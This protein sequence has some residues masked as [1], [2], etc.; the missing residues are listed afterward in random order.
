MEKL[1]E[2]CIPDYPEQEIK[3]IVEYL[4]NSEKEE[5]VEVAKR[6]CRTY[7]RHSMDFLRG[8]YD[9]YKNCH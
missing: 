2:K 7:Q 9:S 5:I 1:V 8:I 6:I 3:D 4:Y